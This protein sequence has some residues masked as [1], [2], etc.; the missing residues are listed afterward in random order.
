MLLTVNKSPSTDVKI[1]NPEKYRFKRKMHTQGHF[2]SPP[3]IDSFHSQYNFSLPTRTVTLC[4]FLCKEQELDA[5]AI[6]LLIKILTQNAVSWILGVVSPWGCHGVFNPKQWCPGLRLWRFHG[7]LLR[8]HSVLEHLQFP[9]ETQVVFWIN[10]SNILSSISWALM[11]VS[12][13]RSCCLHSWN[14]AEPWGGY[15]V[16]WQLLFGA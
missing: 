6:Y 13:I 4:P 3:S 10:R 2:F 1:S 16:N 11:W 8:L 12:L 14:N 5:L 7:C 15:L 9:P